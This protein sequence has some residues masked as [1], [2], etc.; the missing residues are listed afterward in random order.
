MTT[1]KSGKT[2]GKLRSR[3]EG[4][5][6]RKMFA[7]AFVAMESLPP[8][9]QDQAFLQLAKMVLEHHP[10]PQRL[11]RYLDDA[12]AR[13]HRHQARERIKR[14]G[15]VVRLDDYRDRYRSSTTARD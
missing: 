7:Y 15:V 11:T 13:I 8:D 3:E 2:Q 4:I 9:R 1:Q 10:E 5:F 6:V 12:R 14:R